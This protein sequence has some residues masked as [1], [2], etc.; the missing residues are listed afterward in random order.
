MHLIHF[1]KRRTAS[2]VEVIFLAITLLTLPLF[3]APKNIASFGFLCAFVGQSLRFGSFGKS[4][5]FD[6][7]ILGLVAVLWIAPLFSE[8]GAVVTPLS[9]APRWT[10]IGLVAF[11]AARLEYHVRHWIQSNL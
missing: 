3:E 9:S 4:S 7:P 6:L 11:C 8:Y 10:L 1:E 5:P 2:P